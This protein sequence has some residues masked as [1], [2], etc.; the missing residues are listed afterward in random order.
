MSQQL[1]LVLLIPPFFSFHIFD[2]KIFFLSPFYLH[3]CLSCFSPRLKSQSPSVHIHKI[4]TPLIHL[5]G[6]RENVRALWMN[7]Q[8]MTDGGGGGVDGL[9][10]PLHEERSRRSGAFSHF[11]HIHMFSPSPYNLQLLSLINI[12]SFCIYLFIIRGGRWVGGIR[13]LLCEQTDLGVL[14]VTVQ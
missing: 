12:Q 1:L 11:R 14:V 9:K 4:S 3:I 5:S 2:L 8:G 6:V 10:W 13:C 7:E